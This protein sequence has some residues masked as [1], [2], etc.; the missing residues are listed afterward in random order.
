MRVGRSAWLA[1][2]VA[3]LLAAGVGLVIVRLPGPTTGSASPEPKHGRLVVAARDGRPLRVLFLGDSLTWG[4]FALRPEEHAFP[5][6]VVDRLRRSGPVTEKDVGRIGFTAAMLLP[7]VAPAGTADLVVVE[8]GTNDANN[9]TLDQFRNDYPAFLDAV[10]KKSPDAA[11]VCAGTWHGGSLARNMDRVIESQ[12]TAHNGRYADLN[13]LFDD[14]RD[15]GPAGTV[16]PVGDVT[17]WFHP[18]DA[19]HA[20]I[21]DAILD[22]LDLSALGVA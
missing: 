10:R 3:A 8:L 14:E 9:T 7:D 1:A 13:A 15:H 19:G 12:C 16:R 11:L 2:L 17:D 21:A 20:G 6:R 22:Q 18:N 5:A 4:A